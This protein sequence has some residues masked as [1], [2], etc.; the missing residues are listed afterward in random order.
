[1]LFSAEQPLCCFCAE[2]KVHKM[3][4]N[5]LEI[6]FRINKKHWDQEPPEGVPWVSTIHQGAPRPPGMPCWL[7]P[8]SCPPDPNSN[9]INTYFWRKNKRGSYIA[10]YDTEPPPPPILHGRPD[11]ELVWGCGEGNLCSFSSPILLHRQFH[12]APYQE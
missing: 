11:L 12:D 4:R 6:Y 8:T 1:M 3:E 10:S 7:V 2:I 5:F 9:S